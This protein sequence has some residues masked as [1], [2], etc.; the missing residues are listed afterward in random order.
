MVNF[1]KR[2]SKIMSAPGQMIVQEWASVLL[3]GGRIG[4]KEFL[5]NQLRQ[6][7]K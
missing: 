7:G 5:G 6:W 1:S 3:E 2:I 4:E